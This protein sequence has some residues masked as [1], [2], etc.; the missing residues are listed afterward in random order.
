MDPDPTS[1]ALISLSWRE[2]RVFF[3]FWLSCDCVKKQKE[4]V[5]YSTFKAMLLF[6]D[7]YP[8][9]GF[10]HSGSRFRIFPSQSCGSGFATLNGQKTSVYLPQELFLSSRTYDPR[11]LSRTF[12]IP[13]PDPGIKKHWIPDP[14]HSYKGTN[15]F[16]FMLAGELWLHA[17]RMPSHRS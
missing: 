10:F 9:S 8:G 3:D 4:D 15:L 16:T 13:N 12:S 7:V 6:R 1:S 2:N 14:Q 11:C 5:R 17:K